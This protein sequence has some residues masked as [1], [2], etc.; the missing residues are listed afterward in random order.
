MERVS[1]LFNWRLGGVGLVS[2]LAI[3]FVMFLSSSPAF[4]TFGN[5]GSSPAKECKS[6]DW[7]GEYWKIDIDRHFKVGKIETSA[8]V[9]DDAI[10]FDLDHKDVTWSNES[11]FAVFRIYEKGGWYLDVN[12]GLWQPGEGGQFSI[13]HSISHVTFCFTEAAMPAMSIEKKTNN[14][15][16]TA[17]DPNY[18]L[19]GD[20]VVWTYDVKNT[21]T[22]ALKD[23][24]VTDSDEGVS[25]AYHSGDNENGLLDPGETWHFKA[26][27]ISEPGPYENTGTA[28]AHAKY[29]PKVVVETSD[30][31][32]YFGALPGIALSVTAPSEPIL[33]GDGFNW[34]IEVSNTGNVP[35][36]SVRVEKDGASTSCSWHEILPGATETCDLADVAM[37]GSESSSF[38]AR[39]TVP[40]GGA[41]ASVESDV[42][43]ATYQVNQP[44][45]ANDDS[46][47]MDERSALDAETNATLEVPAPGVLDNDSD[48]D[49]DSLSVVSFDSASAMGGAVAMES[50]GSFAFTP[51]AYDWDAQ[52]GEEQ[53]HYT[54][55]WEYTVSDGK[56]GSAS[57]TVEVV[58]NRVVCTGETV[59][60]VDPVVSGFFGSFTA[61]NDVNNQPAC[62]EYTV[63]ASASANLV[64]LDV[65][66][67][68]GAAVFFSGALSGEPEEQN[69]DGEFVLGV[70]Y[71]PDLDGP[72]EFRPLLACDGTPTIEDDIV[73]D[74]EIPSGE[75]WCLAGSR[76]SVSDGELIPLYLVYGV[77]DPGF[78]FR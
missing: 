57:A 49:G 46:Y 50:N 31:S 1:R 37:V 32:G 55:S 62:K 38:V 3:L 68:Q 27:G 30:T 61:L 13:W 4:G 73:T 52:V 74:A 60:G 66:S 19:V 71:D 65:P 5:W 53:Y 58:V 51:G 75:T 59:T 54:D 33:E 26:K 20:D 29:D 34:L 39:G 76:T 7:N 6:G 64:S 9:A 56:G 2:I 44:P 43:V 72:A 42:I 35:L 21:G 12:K 14:A 67:G 24:A 22:V 11:A 10:D 28:T 47:E 77:E 36:G 23:V 25:P 41:E 48:P 18:I 15:D 78:S 16:P 63:A 17:A 69:E 40:G 70:L 45:I 8:N